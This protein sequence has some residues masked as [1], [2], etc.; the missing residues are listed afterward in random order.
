VKTKDR[1]WPNAPA[2]DVGRTAAQAPGCVLEPRRGM[3]V[4]RPRARGEA[5][6]PQL[7]PAPVGLQAG[8]PG[9]GGYTHLAFRLII[10]SI[11][12]LKKN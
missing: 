11:S 8:R 7:P 1:G 9:P 4:R 5:T 2:E 3:S 12:I 10:Y 6:S